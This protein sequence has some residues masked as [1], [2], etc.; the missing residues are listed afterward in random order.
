MMM[1]YFVSVGCKGMMTR[2]VIDD[3]ADKNRVFECLMTNR[4]E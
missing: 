2:F 1:K 3:S 4:D